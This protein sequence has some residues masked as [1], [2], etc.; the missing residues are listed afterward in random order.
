MNELQYLYKIGLKILIGMFS[1]WLLLTIPGKSEIKKSQK[2]RET[3]NENRNRWV[4]WDDTKKASDV[5]YL[6]VDNNKV[7]YRDTNKPKSND[8]YKRSRYSDLNGIT[9]TSGNVVIQTDLSAEEIIEQL[10]IDVNDIIDYYGGDL[11]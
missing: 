1:I 6:D 3:I 10:D 11:R 8:L 9:I 4:N 5:V 2:I 7:V